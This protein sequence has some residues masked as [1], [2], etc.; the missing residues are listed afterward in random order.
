MGT[1]FI[2]PIN[3]AKEVDKSTIE[4]VTDSD[5]NEDLLVKII[6]K[7]EDNKWKIN[8]VEEIEKEQ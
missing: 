7:I 5:G 1:P 2:L 4:A 3:E 8:K 6:L